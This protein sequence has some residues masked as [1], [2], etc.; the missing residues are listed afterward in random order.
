MARGASRASRNVSLNSPLATSHFAVGRSTSSAAGDVAPDPNSL[1]PGRGKL[2]RGSVKMKIEFHRMTKLP[3]SVLP[4]SAAGRREAL[5]LLTTPQLPPVILGCSGAT[6]QSRCR[7]PPE[8]L[9]RRACFDT[10]G[11]G[12]ETQAL[13]WIHLGHSSRYH[14]N[15]TRQVVLLCPRRTGRCWCPQRFGGARLCSGWVLCEAD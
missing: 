15:E 11:H 13:Q 12:R 3:G 8:G 7:V 14:L 10:A 5:S 9:C 1:V 6:G 4:S 2:N